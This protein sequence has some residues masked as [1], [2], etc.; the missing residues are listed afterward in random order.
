MEENS[1]VTQSGRCPYTNC[2]MSNLFNEHIQG[3][4]AKIDGRRW[5]ADLWKSLTIFLL[6]VCAGL[7]IHIALTK[8][9]THTDVQIEIQKQ[10]E[11]Y[12]AKLEIIKTKLDGIGERIEGMRKSFDATQ[13]R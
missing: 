4:N 9:M 11:V 3:I 13:K 10:T 12:D 8:P 1:T 5:T 6:P 7:I 2:P